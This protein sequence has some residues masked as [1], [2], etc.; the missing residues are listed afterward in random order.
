MKEWWEDLGYKIEPI[1][2]LLTPILYILVILTCIKFLVG[3]SGIMGGME[4]PSGR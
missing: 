4:L 3:C 2:T 1:L